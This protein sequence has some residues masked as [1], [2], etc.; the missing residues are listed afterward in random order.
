MTIYSSSESETE[1]AGKR[2]AQMLGRGG[3]AALSGELGAGKTAF[4]RGLAEGLGIASRVTSPTFAIVNEYDGRIPL[5]HFDLY[6]I[7]GEDEL[8]E[9]GWDDYLERGGVVAAE[10]ER[11]RPPKPFRLR[12]FTSAL[13]KRASTPAGSTSIFREETHENT[14]D[15]IVRQGGVRGPRRRR[16]T[17]RAVFSQRGPHPQR[18]AHENGRG[19]ARRARPGAPRSRL[20]GRGARARLVY[21]HPHRR[22]GGHRPGLGRGPAGVRRLDA[23]GDGAPA[24][25]A[26]TPSSAPSWTPGETRFTRRLFIAKAAALHGSRRTGPSRLTDL[27]SEAAASKKPY[28]LLGDGAELAREAFE[29]SGAVFRLAPALLRLQSAWGVACAALG[30]PRLAPGELKPNYLRLSQ[31]ERERRERRRSGGV[32]GGSAV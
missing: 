18:D 23:R 3:V 25:R 12:P 5:F 30:A 2:L 14:C 10:C 17:G 16:Q 11:K 20:R 15:R 29:A 19:P 1:A 13:K 32:N 26:G 9:L 28:L 21:R 31:A 4:V 8:F 22:L 24:P 27:A 6:R 7:T